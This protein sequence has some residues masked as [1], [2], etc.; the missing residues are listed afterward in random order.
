MKNQRPSRLSLK[1]I[2]NRVMVAVKRY[3]SGMRWLVN[4]TGIT[5]IKSFAAKK[6][7]EETPFKYYI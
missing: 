5:A 6:R 4:N 1:I 7:T 3:R 2:R